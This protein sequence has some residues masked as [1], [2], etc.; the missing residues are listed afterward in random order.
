LKECKKKPSH[1]KHEEFRAILTNSPS[2]PINDVWIFLQRYQIFEK[3]IDRNIFNFLEIAEK[4][5]M[6]LVLLV[7]WGRLR[8]RD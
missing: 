2:D 7:N 8:N 5:G 1:Q 3:P 6:A 4:P